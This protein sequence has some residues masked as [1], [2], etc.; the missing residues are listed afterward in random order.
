MWLA[1]IVAAG[2]LLTGCVKMRIGLDVAADESAVASI[3]LGMTDQAKTFLKQQG[4]ETNLLELLGMGDQLTDAVEKQTWTDGEYEWE[5]ISTEIPSLQMLGLVL[6]PA[7]GNSEMFSRFE[8]ERRPGP[9]KDIFTVNI[10]AM[11]WGEDMR[12]DLSGEDNPFDL[13]PTEFVEMQVAIRLPGKLLETNAVSST[14]DTN[15]MLWTLDPFT[16]T[17]IIATS[18]VEHP[19]QQ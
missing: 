19:A 8:V 9:T 7:S 4:D 10:E 17:L 11:P 18:E 5:Q 16:R 12:E 1:I 14:V 13:D 15:E 6:G 2:M 3:S